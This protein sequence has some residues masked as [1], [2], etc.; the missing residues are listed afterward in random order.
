[1]EDKDIWELEFWT[2][3]NGNCPVK[4]TLDQ[5]RNKDPV[6]YKRILKKISILLRYTVKQLFKTNDLEDLKRGGLLELKIH[7]GNEFR[8]LGILRKNNLITVYIAIHAFHKKNR[9]IKN[10]DIQIA[11]DRLKK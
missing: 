10:S 9:K 4:E 7:A 1:M 6:F 2:N 3:S 8:M 11:L 5:I